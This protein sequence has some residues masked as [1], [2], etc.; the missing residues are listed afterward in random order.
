[1]LSVG[2]VFVKVGG[3]MDLLFVQLAPPDK[4][5][6]KDGKICR[7]PDVWGFC[8]SGAM[9]S[10][11]SE[12][13]CTA[14]TAGPLEVK[15][16]SGAAEFWQGGKRLARVTGLPAA[17]KLVVSLRNKGQFVKLL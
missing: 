1:M 2:S 3:D 6:S 15:V 10:A 4:N 5:I 11:G 14:A 16:Q 12:S 8:C 17:V 7:D 9:Y 13:D